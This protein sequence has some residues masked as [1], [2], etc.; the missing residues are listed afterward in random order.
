MCPTAQ[1][2]TTLNLTPSRC[3]APCRL[4]GLK[5]VLS[6][7]VTFHSTHSSPKKTSTKTTTSCACGRAPRNVRTVHEQRAVS[8][9]PRGLGDPWSLATTSH[10][11]HPKSCTF[12]VSRHT[13]AVLG[14]DGFLPEMTMTKITRSACSLVLAP[15]SPQRVVE[16]INHIYHEKI[17]TDLAQAKKPDCA[18]MATEGPTCMC[19]AMRCDQR[20]HIVPADTRV[21]SRKKDSSFW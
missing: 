18:R 9:R 3:A 19:S 20:V 1:I 5:P 11:M 7:P 10:S 21:S 6:S 16:T 14:K 2:R 8:P 17:S 15:L 13:V 12:H 4:A